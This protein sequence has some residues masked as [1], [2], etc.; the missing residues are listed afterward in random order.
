METSC[1][2]LHWLL[3]HVHLTPNYSSCKEIQKFH[4]MITLSVNSAKLPRK[5]R[6]IWENLGKKEMIRILQFLIEKMQ[7]TGYISVI[8]HLGFLPGYYFIIRIRQ[9]HGW[10]QVPV[11]CSLNFHFFHVKLRGLEEDDGRSC[12]N[13]D[14]NQVWQVMLTYGNKTIKLPFPMKGTETLIWRNAPFASAWSLMIYDRVFIWN[15]KLPL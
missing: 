9:Q 4:C 7:T 1:P 12:V 6:A 15:R 11:S 14:Y 2:P 5:R 10:N 3:W 13:T 8:S